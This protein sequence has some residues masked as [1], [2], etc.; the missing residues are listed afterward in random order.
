M[1]D[2][3]SAEIKH[4]KLYHGNGFSISPS[5]ICLSCSLGTN[6]IFLRFFLS[7]SFIILYVME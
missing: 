5:T 7:A 2:N 1:L 6:S 3:S 4:Q